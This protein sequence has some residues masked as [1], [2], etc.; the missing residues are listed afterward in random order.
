M[1]LANTVTEK[2][3]I[4]LEILSNK[5][6]IR[7]MFSELHMD[8]AESLYAKITEV[9]EAKREAYE[10]ESAEREAKLNALKE[11]KDQL[12]AKGLN[13]DDLISLTQGQPVASIHLPKK[14]RNVKAQPKFH[15]NYKVDGEDLVYFGKIGGRKPDAFVNY[16]KDNMM[17]LD[18]VVSSEDREAYLKAKTQK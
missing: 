3:D 12:A 16:L 2:R 7:N 13:I 5:N 11:I 1:Q 15:F 14:K 10:A 6:S 4:T 9:M 18:D 8:E 17:T